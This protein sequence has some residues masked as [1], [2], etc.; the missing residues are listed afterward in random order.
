MPQK[1]KSIACIGK[2][3]VDSKRHNWVT[4]IFYWKYEPQTLVCAIFTLYQNMF[5]FLFQASEEGKIDNN[6]NDFK[7]SFASYCSR[8]ILDSAK[9][10]RWH[11]WDQNLFTSSSQLFS[12]LSN[13]FLYSRNK[14]SQK[15]P[16]ARHISP[17]KKTFEK[18]K[19]ASLFSSFCCT[20][21]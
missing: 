1:S 2:T 9:Q 15:Y 19:P 16:L 17:L 5:C 3:D 18:F 12:L 7:I 10:T 14:L 6:K 13:L 21:F 11:L 20:L 8:A 4:N